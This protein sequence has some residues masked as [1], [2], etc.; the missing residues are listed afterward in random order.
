MGL[1]L[2]PDRPPTFT[3]RQPSL[4]N[5]VDKST[6]LINFYERPASE[7]FTFSMSVA[8]KELRDEYFQSDE[9]EF[10]D[11]SEGSGDFDPFLSYSAA[12]SL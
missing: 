7:L 4:L 6:S 2:V 5:K 12:F 3:L 10:L 1:F 8:P 9:L 11:E